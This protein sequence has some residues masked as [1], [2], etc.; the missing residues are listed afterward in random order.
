MKEKL[1]IDG[2]FWLKRN[3]ESK[4]GRDKIDLLLAIEKCG[5]ISKAAKE[6]GISYKTAWDS[7]DLLNNLYKDILVEKTVGGNSGG[8]ARL[9][10]KA[11]EMIQLYQ[12]VEEEHKK[13][14]SRISER[15]DDPFELMNFLNRI[16]MKTSARNQF[17]G[18]IKNIEEGAVNS[19]ISLSLKGNQEI[20]AVITN[21][22]VTN[23]GLKVGKDV[24]ALIKASFIFI[25][26]DK[27]LSI[28]TE[29]KLYGK[30]FSIVKGS[31]NDE[32]ILELNGGNKLTSIITRQATEQLTLKEGEEV[33]AFFNASS[34][35]LATE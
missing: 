5:S 17:Y 29:N 22:S 28:S 32:I 13:F 3:K 18:K 31:V 30:I 2:A 10:A 26:K 16:S 9:T 8:G 6:V 7:I 15:M 35:I 11:K 34:V 4:L 33:C 23:L 24:Y 19:E 21:Q 14:I 1:Q 27:N 20:T 25:S 12:I